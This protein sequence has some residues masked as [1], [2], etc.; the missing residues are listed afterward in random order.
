MI[1]ILMTDSIH[2]QK[3]KARDAKRLEV[4]VTICHK[5][6]TIAY[7]DVIDLFECLCFTVRK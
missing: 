6:H 5:V 7:L 4:V 2:F 1:C 3:Q